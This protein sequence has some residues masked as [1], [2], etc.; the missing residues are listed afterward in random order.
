MLFAA[1][2]DAIAVDDIP[3]LV[4]LASNIDLSDTHQFIEVR[5]LFVSRQ[6]RDA[7]AESLVRRRSQQAQFGALI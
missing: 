1:L 6:V 7:S 5:L 4:S 3:E 2:L